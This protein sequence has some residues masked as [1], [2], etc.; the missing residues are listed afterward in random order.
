MRYDCSLQ[1]ERLKMLE[2]DLETWCA[3]HSYVTL[4]QTKSVAFG[5]VQSLIGIE[6]DLQKLAEI[7]TIEKANR[8]EF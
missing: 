8:I 1:N 3:K 7:R 6:K 4:A 2:F 5:F